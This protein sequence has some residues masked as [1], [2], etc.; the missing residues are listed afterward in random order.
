MNRRDR[1]KTTDKKDVR[2]VEMEAILA[3]YFK[4]CFV[5]CFDVGHMGLKAMWT[6]R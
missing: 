2:K 1:K 3:K 5:I 4:I 6:C